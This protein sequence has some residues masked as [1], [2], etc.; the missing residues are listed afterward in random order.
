M[1]T[2]LDLPSGH[3]RPATVDDLDAVL[4]L[5]HDPD[6]R[7]YLC[8]DALL[9]RETVAAMLAESERLDRS[10]MGLWSIED[11][12]GG[13]VGIAGLQPVSEALAG[14]PEMAGE[15]E[16]IIALHPTFWGQG[17]ARQTL[18]ALASYARSN[19][20]LSQ[21]FAAVDE[22]N[23]RSHRLM[24]TCGFGP[25]QTTDG[26]AHKLIIYRL[27]LGERGSS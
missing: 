11:F 13:F 5:L 1:K 20:H 22:P 3:L 24:Q 16:P 23:Q 8:D 10:G 4:N 26:P 21:L 14:V 27:Q 7:R 15:V 25:I 17:L 2:V 19:L 12:S 9:P 6:V 18:C